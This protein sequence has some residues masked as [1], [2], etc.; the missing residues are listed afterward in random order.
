MDGVCF[1]LTLP[2]VGPAR[3]GWHVH[4]LSAG[5]PLALPTLQSDP[6][7]LTPGKIVKVPPYSDACVN[8]ILIE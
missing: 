8:G 1:W 7:L 2:A 4:L 3:W 6:S 5:P